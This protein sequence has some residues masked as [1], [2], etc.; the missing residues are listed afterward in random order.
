MKTFSAI[1][2]SRRSAGYAALGDELAYVVQEFLVQDVMPEGA[3]RDADIGFATRGQDGKVP[4][5]MPENRPGQ[6]GREARGR[7]EAQEFRRTDLPAQ[8]VSPAQVA[9]TCDEAPALEV[10]AA[11]IAQA[12]IAVGDRVAQLASQIDAREGAQFHGIGEEPNPLRGA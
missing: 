10:V 5:Q 12:N 8:R 3:E 9:D 7:G 1:L 4:A 11:G 2:S 6:R